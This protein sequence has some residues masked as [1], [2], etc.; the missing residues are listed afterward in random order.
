MPKKKV[1]LDLSPRTRRFNPQPHWTG[2]GSV[3][4]SVI[5]ANR[6]ADQATDC[7]T[8]R[9][10]S[11]F[12]Q[13]SDNSISQNISI[14]AQ[15]GPHKQVFLTGISVP[16]RTPT[17]AYFFWEEVIAGRT[18]RRAAVLT[19]DTKYVGSNWNCILL[20]FAL[21]G[22]NGEVYEYSNK[23]GIAWLVQKGNRMTFKS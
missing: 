3:Q 8:K 13:Y 12:I 21:I 2:T 17:V 16:D 23:S 1:K 18:L 9:N 4:I 22:V 7:T 5:V 19:R 14:A 10:V 15:I 20:Q 6:T 11:A